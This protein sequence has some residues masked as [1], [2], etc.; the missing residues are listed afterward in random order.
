MKKK[1][2]HVWKAN[3]NDEITHNWQAHYPNAGYACIFLCL[4]EKLWWK[5]SSESDSS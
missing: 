4:T 2:F 1:P 5:Q 3:M